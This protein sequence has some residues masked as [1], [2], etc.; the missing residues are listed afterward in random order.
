MSPD[1]YAARRS[2]AIAALISA[3]ATPAL[4][5]LAPGDLDS[6][7]GVGG[8]VEARVGA[9]AHDG[10]AA[11]LLPDGRILV[12]GAAFTGDPGYSIVLARFLPDGAADTSFGVNG[13]V[14]AVL[15]VSFR[16]NAMAVQPDGKIVVAGST[17]NALFGANALIDMALARFDADGNLDPS[18]GNGG[19]VLTDVF[20]N[21]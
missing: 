9:T 18:F 3:L 15:P 20:G 12:A 13:G 4:A 14:S 10:G 7:F 17:D 11:V 5:Q 19:V 6:S 1:N 21:E 8:K 16:A 2:L